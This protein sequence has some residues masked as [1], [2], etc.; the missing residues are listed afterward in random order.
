MGSKCAVDGIALAEPSEL[1]KLLRTKRHIWDQINPGREGDLRTV[2][3]AAPRQERM[4][5][6]LA[7]LAAAQRAG[8]DRF[9][10]LIRV[11]PVTFT[12]TKTLGALPRVRCGE[13]FWSPNSD[14]KLL[15]AAATWEEVVTAVIQKSHR[16]PEQAP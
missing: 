14:A 2:R 10:I 4:Q 7:C 15:S 8:F 13:T 9:T 3:F 12:H 5:S 16:N 6:V 1:E 11:Q